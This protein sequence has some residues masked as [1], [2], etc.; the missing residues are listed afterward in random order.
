LLQR[1]ASSLE[2]AAVLGARAAVLR[3]VA[4]VLV[5][6]AGVSGAMAPRKLWSAVAAVGVRSVAAMAPT[7]GSV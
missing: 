1:F 2:S 4:A 5:A 6:L 3:A 7:R